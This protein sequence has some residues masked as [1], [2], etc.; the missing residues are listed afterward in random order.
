[1]Q[2]TDGHDGFA[3]GVSQNKEL[4][5]LFIQPLAVPTAPARYYYIFQEPIRTQ[6]SDLDNPERVEQLYRQVRTH[7]AL[8]WHRGLDTLLQLL[9]RLYNAEGVFVDDIKVDPLAAM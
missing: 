7:S 2:A 1:M 6:R 9:F 4:E 5:D 3:R 8:C